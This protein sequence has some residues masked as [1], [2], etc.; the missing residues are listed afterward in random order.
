MDQEG[1]RKQQVKVNILNQSFTLVTKGDPQE[2]ID[3]AQKVDELMSGIAARSQNLDT[4]RVA[5]LACLHLADQLQQTEERLTSLQHQ[6]ELK[7]RQFAGFLDS[8]L[9][10]PGT[11]S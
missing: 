2:T 1:Q 4:T 5:V 8:A 10:S 9:Q 6:V 11:T 7:A 3:L